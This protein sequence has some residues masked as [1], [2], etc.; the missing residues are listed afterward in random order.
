VRT[1]TAHSASGSA[2]AS[3]QIDAYIADLDSALRGPR[4]AR[5]DLLA[6]ARDGLADATD[7]YTSAGLPPGEAAR[8]ALAEFGE[9]AAVAPAYQDELAAAQGRRTAFGVLTVHLLVAI[10]GNLS[11]RL[12]DFWHGRRPGALYLFIAQATDLAQYAIVTA[13]VLLLLA[14]GPLSRYVP[15]RAL[16]RATG[17]IT[18][19]VLGFLLATAVT[20]MMSTPMASA[21]LLAGAATLAVILLP[22]GVTSVALGRGARRCL[23]LAR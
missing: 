3:P 20:L 6:E 7:A 15:A 18:F 12:F 16:L 8:R 5:A 23:A 9:V 2:E 21:S 22:G 19:F 1:R 10:E 17:G 4:R 14:Y 13:L 11:W